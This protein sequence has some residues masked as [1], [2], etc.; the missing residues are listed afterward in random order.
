MR[1]I[2][3]RSVAIVAAA[4]V[5]IGGAGAAWAYWTSNGTQVVSGTAGTSAP[6]TISNFSVQGNVAPTNPVD[7][8]FQIN[9]PNNYPVTIGTLSLTNF[10]ASSGACTAAL[11]AATFEFNDDAVAPTVPKIVANGNSGS[12][13]WVDAVRLTENPANECKGE[14]FS[15][16]INVD[17]DSA[18]A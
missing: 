18:A 16:T 3:K 2:T 13:T 7:V 12:I 17:A 5:G 9:N 4:V 10:T 1:K 15:F 6:V 11:A 8:V 14:N